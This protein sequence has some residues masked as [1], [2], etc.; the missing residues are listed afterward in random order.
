MC[1]SA[2]RVR[3]G[4]RAPGGMSSYPSVPMKLYGTTTSPYV[5]KVRI[6]ATA[7]GVPFDLVDTRSDAG[8]AELAR[9]SPLGKVPVVELPD[10]R[11][12]P[13]SGLV[14]AWLWAE[15]APALPPAR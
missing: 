2:I 7:A 13:D 4:Y 5:R 3:V 1:V 10:G 6:L 14:A 8:A 15:H 9:L 12:L 11:A